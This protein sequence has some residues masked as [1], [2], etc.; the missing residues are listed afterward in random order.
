VKSSPILV[1]YRKQLGD[2]VLLQPALQ[3]LAERY[4]VNVLVRTRPVFTD[5]LALMPGDVRLAGPQDRTFSPGYCL[6]NKNSSFL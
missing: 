1:I 4:G 5:V 6:D 3:L 2:L